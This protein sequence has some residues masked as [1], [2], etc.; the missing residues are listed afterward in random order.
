MEGCWPRAAE[1][2]G[3][4]AAPAIGAAGATGRASQNLNAYVDELSTGRVPRPTKLA[5]FVREASSLRQVDAQLSA[6]G[7][8]A[9]LFY[10]FGLITSEELR[11]NDTVS[12]AVDTNF[13]GW[14]RDTVQDAVRTA[15]KHDVLKWH[16]R[17]LKSGLEERFQ[18]AAVQASALTAGD[19][20][21]AQQ[22]QHLEVTAML[23]AAIGVALQ[24]GAEY[25]VS[26]AEQE[27]QVEALKVL[28]WGMQLVA[29]EQDSVTHFEGL[30]VQ[31][32]RTGGEGGPGAGGRGP[33]R[34]GQRLHPAGSSSRARVAST[35][36]PRPRCSST[37]RTRA[38]KS[39]TRTWTRTA[40]STCA[41][42]T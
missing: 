22:L 11:Q 6:S 13:L 36:A 3:A 37:T 4:R 21:K 24:V 14:L 33:M 30:T 34:Q 38:L 12:S 2:L 8:L 31:V 5:F 16:I 23:H 7:S 1:R 20:S 42:R 19:R 27:R 9:P 29:K 41:P 28:E 32:R 40:A 25:A 10:A 26:L 39:P 35:L 15:E 18:L 17:R